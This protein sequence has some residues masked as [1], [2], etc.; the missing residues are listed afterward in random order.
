MLSCLTPVTYNVNMYKQP[1]KCFF[2]EDIA[3]FSCLR[4]NEIERIITNLLSKKC[5]MNVIGYN[6]YD[7]EYWCKNV[8]N[9][10][11]SSYYKINISSYYKIKIMSYGTISTIKIMPVVAVKQTIKK[12][13]SALKSA[14]LDYE[15]E[16]QM[17]GDSS[18]DLTE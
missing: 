9:N 8:K 16:V 6:Q 13:E 4:K 12:F 17:S 1:V 5:E 2:I 15:F 14:I 11:I 3:I 7:E 18:S 10:S